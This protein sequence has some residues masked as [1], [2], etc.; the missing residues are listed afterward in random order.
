M[1]TP[2]LK[3][4]AKVIAVKT[5]MNFHLTK[6][7]WPFSSGMFNFGVLKNQIKALNYFYLQY[8]WEIPASCI[9]LYGQ[10]PQHTCAVWH[11][12]VTQDITIWIISVTIISTLYGGSCEQSVAQLWQCTISLCQCPTQTF[13]LGCLTLNHLACYEWPLWSILHPLLSTREQLHAG[14][15]V[16]LCAPYSDWVNPS[17]LTHPCPWPVHAFLLY[18]CD[19]A[20]CMGRVGVLVPAKCA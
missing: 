4:L 14:I 6:F 16:H 15:R 8:V 5:G 13:S 10:Y 20:V 18:N 19:T 17:L 7:K 11:V 9:H 12:Y 2:N 3:V 1:K